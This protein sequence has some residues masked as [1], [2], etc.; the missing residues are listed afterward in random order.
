MGS[1]SSLGMRGVGSLA[2]LLAT[3]AYSG[4][5]GLTKLAAAVDAENLVKV[6]AQAETV[7][8]VNAFQASPTAALDE[9][10]FGSYSINPY[11]WFKTGRIVQRMRDRGILVSRALGKGAPAVRIVDGQVVAN[12]PSFTSFTAATEEY[13]HA[14]FLQIVGIPVGE[15]ILANSV[16]RYAHEVQI[17]NLMMAAQSGGFFGG[18]PLLLNYVFLL[19][20]RIY[21]EAELSA[22]LAK[23]PWMLKHPWMSKFPRI[24]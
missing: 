12:I 6:A 8:R 7:P 10:K 9:A 17:K 24:R 23:C 5:I 3:G 18:N 16:L 1:Y 2:P 19:N 21:Y 11:Q 15:E 13:L 4:A 22:W 14:R 20:A